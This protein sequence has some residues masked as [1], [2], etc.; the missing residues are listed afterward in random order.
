MMNLSQ[1]SSWTKM[2]LLYTEINNI[3]YAEK[4]P[5]KTLWSIVIFGY[6]SCSEGR[7]PSTPLKHAGM[8]C[9]RRRLQAVLVASQQLSSW[10]HTSAG[11]GSCMIPLRG[12]GYAGTLPAPAARTS[13]T[14]MQQTNNHSINHLTM[15]F[16]FIL[17]HFILYCILYRIA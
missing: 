10:R 3:M 2:S 7:N 17:L 11:S 1:C 12:R 5:Y 4:T 8:H 13:P 6:F 16:Y 9:G 14:E 15:D